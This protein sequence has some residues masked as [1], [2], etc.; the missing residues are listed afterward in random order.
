MNDGTGRWMDNS[1]KYTRILITIAIFAA[2]AFISWQIY[3]FTGKGS[4]SVNAKPADA[5]IV[6]DK[7]AYT[8]KNAQDISLKPGEHTVIV[9]LDGFNTI[10][11][12]ITMGWQDNQSVSYQLT[13]K[14]FKD[15]YQNLSQDPSYTNYT[16]EQE[17]FFLE[18]TWAT[19]YIV[20][21]GE[22]EAISLAV[23]RRVNGAWRLVFHDHRLPAD[24]ASTLPPEVYNHIKDF[25]EWKPGNTWFK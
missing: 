21:G 3:L 14:K 5:S 22:T 8:T 12:T 1:M 13:P 11:Q 23:I 2:L 24:A 10:E 15:I 7:K 20:D 9:A 17:Q 6:I 16:A 18:N 25:T 4:F 19:A